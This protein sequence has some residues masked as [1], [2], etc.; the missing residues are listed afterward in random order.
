MK[1]FNWSIISIVFCPFV[2]ADPITLTGTVTQTVPVSSY[3]TATKATKDITLLRYRLTDNALKQLQERKQ[4][5]N[6]SSFHFSAQNLPKR[7]QLGM[8]GVPVFDQGHHGT[9]VTFATTAAIDALFGKEYVSQLCSLQLGNYLAKEGYL[10]SGW[11]GSEGE[12]VL[13]QLTRF[14]IVSK[15]KEQSEGCGGLTS[16][17]LE[18]PAPE[19]EMNIEN[20]HRLSQD[21][22]DDGIYFYPILS[23]NKAFQEKI[24]T[25]TTLE[26]VKKI[27]HLGDRVVFGTILVHFDEGVA[28]AIGRHHKTDDTW[29]LTPEIARDAYLKHELFGHEMVITGYDDEAIA[30]DHA[31]RKH[32]GLLTIRN[33]WGSDVADKGDFYMSYDYFKLFVHEANRVGT[34]L[35]Q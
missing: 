15:E 19:S 18:K 23:R 27:L 26:Y 25:I 16:Y 11:D 32:Q 6:P 7:V 13:S 28:G 2:H 14:G 31:G 35:P 30:I 29:V 22:D 5:I 17:P 24:D 3:Q 21:L 10:P 34:Y 33:S 9:C 12:I 4:H 8:N 1:L 20:Y